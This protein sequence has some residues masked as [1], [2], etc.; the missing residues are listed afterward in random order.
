MLAIGAPAVMLVAPV[1][2]AF[3]ATLD[4]GVTGTNS[5][6]FQLGSAN[7]L[8]VGAGLI[9]LVALVAE[10]GGSVIGRPLPTAPLGGALLLLVLGSLAQA[11]GPAAAALV[12]DTDLQ[13][14]LQLLAAAGKVAI[15][16]GALAAAAGLV[17][18]I[19]TAGRAGSEEAH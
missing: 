1:A 17:S 5:V 10:L 14:N 16:L 15:G 12:S 4:D 11:I 13:Q 19:A 7:S 8:V 3:A 9:A 2:L 6:Y 18:V